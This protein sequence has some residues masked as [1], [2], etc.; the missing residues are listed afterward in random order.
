LESN[1]FS[2]FLTNIVPL[3]KYSI[4]VHRVNITEL[5]SDQF[6][7]A[8]ENPECGK[9]LHENADSELRRIPNS[10]DSHY[11]MVCPYCKHSWD[12]GESYLDRLY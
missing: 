6:F 11:F 12:T 10:P 2:G 7:V 8:C 3:K 9:E 5:L 4:P 1:N